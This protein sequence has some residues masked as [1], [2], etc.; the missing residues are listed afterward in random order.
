MEKLKQVHIMIKIR[1]SLFPIEAV[2][3]INTSTEFDIPLGMDDY[4]K[5]DMLTFE[6][7]IYYWITGGNTIEE[8]YEAISIYDLDPSEC[9]INSMKHKLGDETFILYYTHYLSFNDLSRRWNE[10][11]IEL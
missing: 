4:C 11:H 7:V 6:N 2:K 3:T 5:L 10:A 1:K 8:L 9:L